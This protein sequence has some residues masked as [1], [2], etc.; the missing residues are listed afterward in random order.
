[1]SNRYPK[2]GHIHTYVYG[3]YL[4]FIK[5]SCALLP[6]NKDGVV[7]KIIHFF[8]FES[9]LKLMQVLLFVIFSKLPSFYRYFRLKNVR[10]ISIHRLYFLW[11]FKCSKR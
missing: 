11:F 10:K 5:R 6:E 9:V 2:N 4:D 3:R 8:I 7:I 1:M